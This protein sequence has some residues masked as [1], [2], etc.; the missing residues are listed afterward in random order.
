MHCC[1]IFILLKVI[2]VWMVLVLAA[3]IKAAMMVV[4]SVVTRYHSYLGK[5]GHH[6]SHIFAERLSAIAWHHTTEASW[7]K[8]P[9]RLT[10]K[11]GTPS[12]N[13]A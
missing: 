4:S 9:T 13:W 7:W 1:T 5:R 11:I 12:C 8:N 2:A 3:I 10:E 6:G